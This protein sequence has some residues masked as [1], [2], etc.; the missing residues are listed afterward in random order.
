[1]NAGYT[2]AITGKGGVGKTT[3]ASSLVAGLIRRGCGPVLAVDA[4]PIA[5]INELL[6]V[7]I[8]KTVG[9]IREEGREAVAYRTDGI[10]K[11]ELVELK[12]SESLVEALDF[13]LI[14]MGRP[15]GP[16]CYCYANHLLCDVMKELSKN[17]PFVVIDNEAG[18][19]NLSRRLCKR[20]DLLII[21][22][23]PSKQGMQTVRRLYNLAKE[24]DIEYAQ[25]AVV[26]NLI[27][28]R[29]PTEEMAG[30]MKETGADFLLALPFD[31]EM[32]IL[33][34]T[35]ASIHTLPFSNP[36]LSEIYGFIS[37]LK[38]DASGK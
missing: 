28:N 29:I 35:G 8:R 36:V 14:A 31:K 12:I 21:A 9:Q 16:G 30:L 11:R 22:G 1:M 27:R 32:A 13:D 23:D 26:I 34:D 20:I 19:E 33:G 4:D 17:Y 15:E 10:S 25:L 3:I 37:H 7:A 38:C 5:C 2:I 24:M 6:G 18:L